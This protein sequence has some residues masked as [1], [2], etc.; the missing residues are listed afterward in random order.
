MDKRLNEVSFGKW[1]GFSH[2]GIRLRFPRASRKWYLGRWT[3]RPPGGES[4]KSLGNRVG[5]FLKELLNDF[6]ARKRG[7]LIVVTHGGPIRMFL[8]H[9]LKTSP[10]VFW[11][12]R[13]DPASLSIIWITKHKQELILLNGLAHLIP[14]PVFGRKGQ[15]ARGRYTGGGINGFERGGRKR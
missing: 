14:P 9:I 3:S 11:R 2:R 10:K 8:V 15:S 12:M 1:E 7:S 13:V 4:L 6:S 5:Y